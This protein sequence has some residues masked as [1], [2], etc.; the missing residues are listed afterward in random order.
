MPLSLDRCRHTL[1]FI[2]LIDCCCALGGGTG[3]SGEETEGGASTHRPQTFGFQRMSTM[4]GSKAGAPTASAL[5]ALLP[6]NQKPKHIQP[7]IHHHMA[8]TSFVLSPARRA[9]APSSDYL[10]HRGDE[11]SQQSL[12]GGHGHHSPSSDSRRQPS[13]TRANRSP[14]AK[15]FHPGETPGGQRLVA[16][17]DIPETGALMLQVRC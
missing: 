3:R 1:V 12:T 4:V 9:A 16:A 7:I 15:G 13:P 8:M 17:G 11:A 5:A 2:L 6:P 10:H 14:L